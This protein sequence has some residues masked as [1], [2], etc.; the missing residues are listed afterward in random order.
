MR[1]ENPA[2]KR[3]GPIRV[4]DR[5]G[6]LVVVERAENGP[7]GKVRIICRCDCGKVVEVFGSSLRSGRCKSCGCLRSEIARTRMRIAAQLAKLGASH[8]THD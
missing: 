2:K 5:F 8:E 3:S 4:G 7:G 1:V 6:R